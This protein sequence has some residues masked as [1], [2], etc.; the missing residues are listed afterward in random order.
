MID[1]ANDGLEWLTTKPTHSVA[2]R[3]WQIRVSVSYP[4]RQYT[5]R[6]EVH[7][8]A[9]QPPHP[10]DGHQTSTPRRRRHQRGD[11]QSQRTTPIGCRCRVTT[12][13]S[14]RPGPPFVTPDHLR[15]RGATPSAG[16][17]PA[18]AKER[19]GARTGGRYSRFT[20]HARWRAA[21][22]SSQYGR[23]GGAAGQFAGH[24][25]KSRI[26]EV[27]TPESPDNDGP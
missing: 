8:C 26:R 27:D 7:K 14:M 12:Q 6:R 20:P 24:P 16:C 25:R 18:P 5:R 4:L 9:A 22:L 2:D 1:L 11:G 19:G 21:A 13:R 17:R 15:G 23:F 10:R 3:L